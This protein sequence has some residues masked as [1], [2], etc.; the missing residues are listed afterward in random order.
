MSVFENEQFSGNLIFD[1]KLEEGREE[2]K[3]F[4]PN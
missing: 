3:T 1:K 4:N 2:E